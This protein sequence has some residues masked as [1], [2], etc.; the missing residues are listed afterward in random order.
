MPVILAALLVA[1]AAGT[2]RAELPAP[3][4]M[5]GFPLLAG[6]QVILMWTPVPGAVK[7]FVYLNG[8]KVAESASFQFTLA[9]P[10]KS[11][12]HQVAVAGI[13]GEG[14]A[15]KQSA[16]GTIRI[17]VIQPPGG[18]SAMT[19]PDSIG[20]RW[21]KAEGAMIYNVYRAESEASEKKLVLSTQ[22]TLIRDKDVQKGKIYYYW[23]T[24][25]DSTGRESG[26]AKPISAKTE[27]AAEVKKEEVIELV[28]V[29]VDYEII[30]PDHPLI[31]PNDMVF[32]KGKLYLVEN[33]G[34]KILILGPDGN[35]QGSFGDSGYLDGQF[36]S[37]RGISIMNGKIAVSD[38]LR[39]MI[40]IFD[41]ATNAFVK[42]FEIPKKDKA[43][44][45][46]TIPSFLAFTPKGTL[47]VVD[48]RNFRIV[49]MD[50][51]GK[52][53][54]YFGEKNS[55]PQFKLGAF[56]SP[57]YLNVDKAGRVYVSDKSYGKIHVLGPD[58]KPLF[59]IGTDKGV[60][61]FVDAGKPAI[62]DKNGLVWVAD[63]MLATI[64]AFGYGD[65]KYRF[66]LFDKDKTILKEYVPKWD[67]GS[68]RVLAMSES[69]QIW[70]IMA[71]NRQL[72]RITKF[73]DPLPQKASR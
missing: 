13:D 23:V 64:Q 34:R 29:R 11:G 45:E 32:S 28:P 3:S 37:P 60:G 24:S 27:V 56:G 62:D 66:G 70:I 65:G 41:E 33:S 5:P 36:M 19:S 71:V 31:S 51:D 9:A 67:I 8:Q 25:K 30:K 40:L 46:K 63:P 6:N 20:V 72:A 69:G 61:S 17:I 58:L 35:L 39:E 43:K 42:E 14:K 16:P 54:A 2:G 4:F 15:G 50:L 10:E 57:T 12:A 7:Y 18:L 55:L 48:S 68:C 52:A 26:F 1:G 73:L 38:E 49:E 21:E 59:A 47:V 22:E 44:E 53:L